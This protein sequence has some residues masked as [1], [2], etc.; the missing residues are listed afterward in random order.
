MNNSTSTTHPLSLQNNPINILPP[1]SKK[2]QWDILNSY[3][4]KLSS[5]GLPPADRI[6]LDNFDKSVLT[7]LLTKKHSKLDVLH[8]EANSS[9]S[10]PSP[11]RH[12]KR[13]SV[14][15]FPNYEIGTYVPGH[16]RTPAV[17][18]MPPLSLDIPTN[19]PAASP[20]QIDP[21]RPPH[22]N[23]IT[24]L[25]SSQRNPQLCSSNEG[26]P[27]QALEVSPL[28][29]TFGPRRGEIPSGTLER[30]RASLPTNQFDPSTYPTF[31]QPSE[32]LGHDTKARQNI[33]S[34]ADWG[35]GGEKRILWEAAWKEIEGN[36]EDYFG[37]FSGDDGGK[38]S[39]WD[40]ILDVSARIQDIERNGS[41]CN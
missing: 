4:D 12:V 13:S 8:S 2:A 31:E 29:P 15:S 10:I 7:T 26:I 17:D 19:T 9:L 22:R 38:E 37:R 39:L 11:R 27:L 34:M 30:R 21:S 28:S 25:V 33:Q 5:D 18:G 40:R 35:T 14:L 23:T 32:D 6:I 1:T 16:R 36:F 3:I 41:R 24:E 20:P